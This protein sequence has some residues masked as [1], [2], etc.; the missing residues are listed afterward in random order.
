M[1]DNQNQSSSLV[2]YIMIG[3]LGVL[4]L[5]SLFLVSQLK[6]RMDVLES[7][8]AT[9]AQKL[10]KKISATESTASN[11]NEKLAE[12]LSKQSTQTQKE[13]AARAA[14]LKKEQEAAVSTLSEEQ[15]KQQAALEG[16]K[17]DVGGVKTDVGGVKTDVSSVKTD[18]D[19]TKAKLATAIGDL[20]GQSSLIATTRDELDVLRHK[21]DRN[22]Y[23]FTLTKGKSPTAVS[24][25]TLL[26]KKADPKKNKFTM[27]VTAD[28]KQ[29]ERKDKG[30]GE[31]MQ[32]ITGRDHL[33]YE[34]VVFNVDKDK[35]TGYV[36]TPKNAPTTITR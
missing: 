8:T 14:Q 13:I 4:S 9:D 24:T 2:Q 15:K 6:S 35:V 3:I 18:L 27:V 19:A 1:S 28:D 30:A 31:L 26:L 22:Y 10:E 17:S 5:V 32:F 20:N 16:V 11:A 12:Q 33:L 25:I 21:G 7:K 36:S 23:D 34:L 29:I